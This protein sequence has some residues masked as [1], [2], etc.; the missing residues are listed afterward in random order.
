VKLDLDLHRLN[1]ALQAALSVPEVRADATRCSARIELVVAE[2]GREAA[3]QHLSL[4]AGAPEGPAIVLKA[5]IAVWCQVFSPVPPVGYQSLGALRRQC[6]GFSI[7][8]NDLALAQAL[9]FLERMLESLRTHFNPV[10]T[11]VPQDRTGLG[12]IKGAYLPLDAA[13]Q[14]WVYAERAGLAQGPPLLMLHTAGADA[15]QWHGLMAQRALR[16]AWSLHAFDLPGHG[17][18]PLP[19]GVANWEWRLTEALYLQWVIGYM[20]AAGLERVAL[21]ACSMGS[22]IGLALLAKVPHRFAGAVL[23]EAPYCSPGRRSKYLNHPEVH[24]GR[25][26]A[27]W[28]GSMLCPSSPKAGKDQATW[29]YSQAAPGIYDGDLAFYSDDFNAHHHTAH[30]AAAR[31]PLWLLTGNYDYSATPADS[32]RIAQEIPGSHFKELSGFGHFPMVE[33]PNGLMPHLQQPLNEIK[34]RF[35]ALSLEAT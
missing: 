31:T 12:Y 9:P 8:G 2:P 16:E 35:S 15:R 11:E 13:Q 21:M 4:W 26:G 28:V 32:Q 7:E 19:V 18:S 3:E 10:P 1:G 30:I 22:A 14:D 17:R 5:S 6:P 27:A 20:D 24:G 23:L 33:N 29:I 34:T 25:L